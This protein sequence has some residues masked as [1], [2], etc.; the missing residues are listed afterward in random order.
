MKRPR[1]D[2]KVAY[3]I[4]RRS[5]VDDTTFFSDD[6][7]R[8]FFKKATWA[9]WLMRQF[10]PDQEAKIIGGRVRGNDL[11]YRDFLPEILPET[12]TVDDYLAAV[13]QTMR[14]IKNGKQPSRRKVRG[15]QEWLRARTGAG[16][17][18]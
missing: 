8:I 6:G 12:V 2:R 9:Q 13:E 4:R 7:R 18:P 10:K 17:E 5:R 3:F 15:F 14:D 1:R 16:G 11:D